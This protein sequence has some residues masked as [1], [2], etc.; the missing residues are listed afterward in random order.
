MADNGAAASFSF[1]ASLAAWAVPARE[2]LRR[3]DKHWDGLASGA[4]VFQRSSSGDRVLLV[5]RASHDSMPDRWE[6]PG[7]AVDDQDASVLHGAARELREEAGLAATR[8]R[9]LVTRG[10]ADP[11]GCDVFTNRSG[12]RM[13]CRFV[14]AVDVAGGDDSSS[15]S[16]SSLD[17]PGPAVTLDPNEHQAY[18]W[19]AED[20]VAAQRIGE[21]PMPI[22]P[23]QHAR[24]HPRGL[25]A[26]AGRAARGG[27]AL[28]LVLP[29]PAARSR[30]SYGV[31]PGTSG[32]RTTWGRTLSPL[33]RNEH[34]HRMVRGRTGA[35]TGYLPAEHMSIS[36]GPARRLPHER[37]HGCPRPGPHTI[38]S[39]ERDITAL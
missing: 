7:G 12:T 18:V 16:S 19:A 5:Q 26:P 8:F 11:P 15:S 4:V 28:M 23:R 31:Q 20:D 33:H 21:R 32:M 9:H 6:V 13:F 27:Q 35:Y 2:W 39:Y 30:P 34:A 38:S 36:C 17:G 29:A 14:F 3:H 10:P 1:D 37:D 25:P 22:T 24:R